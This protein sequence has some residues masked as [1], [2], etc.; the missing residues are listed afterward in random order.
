MYYVTITHNS[1]QYV[2]RMQK[3]KEGELKPLNQLQ[4]SDTNPFIVELK[5]R[6]YLQPRANTIIA[7]GQQL[8]DTTTGEVIDDGVLM[9]VR[10]VVDKSQFAKLYAS[11]IGLLYELSR[12][13]V[14]VF[15]YLAKVMDYDNKAIFDYSREAGKIGYKSTVPPLKGLR[16]L[17]AKQIIYPH[18][19]QGIWW[20]NPT[21]ICKGERFLKYVEWVTNERHER[22][23]AKR[24]RREE[25]AEQTADKYDNMDEDTKRQLYYMEQAEERKEPR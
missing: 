6:M 16:E 8:V 9:G 22:D 2:N 1:A 4:G 13:A 7:K 25:L 5:G 21:L 10:R 19:L 12:P 3:K 11:E 17:I 20:L 14:K 15:M 23:E 18:T 24:V